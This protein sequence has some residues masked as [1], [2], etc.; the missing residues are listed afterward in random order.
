MNRKIPLKRPRAMGGKLSRPCWGLAVFLIALVAMLPQAL[1]FQT[2]A[3]RQERSIEALRAGELGRDDLQ[4]MLSIA[5]AQHEIVKILISQ[6]RYERVLP[7][8]RKI[9]ELK[10]PVK[11]EK[12]VAQSASLIANELSE[13]KQFALGHTVLQEALQAMKLNGNK[14]SILKIQAFIYKSEGNLEKAIESLEQAV[15]LERRR[16]QD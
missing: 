12:A 11:Y 14:A 13:N 3:A 16:N 4:N 5:E 6:G 8:M 2:G 10:L 15:A 7:E 1:A 9:Y